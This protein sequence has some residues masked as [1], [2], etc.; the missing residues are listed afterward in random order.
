VYVQL[1]PLSRIEGDLSDTSET[2]LPS[3]I[4]SEFSINLS[5]KPRQQIHHARTDRKFT[6]ISLP[7]Y[8]VSKTRNT[9]C[10]QTSPEVVTEFNLFPKPPG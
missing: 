7:S 8:L 9:N 3:E 5:L 1:F 6:A 2:Q 4:M 10:N